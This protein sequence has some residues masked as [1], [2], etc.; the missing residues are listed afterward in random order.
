VRFVEARQ[1]EGGVLERERSVV[2]VVASAN[3]IESKSRGKA[4]MT[5]IHPYLPTKRI[6]WLASALMVAGV[7]SGCAADAKVLDAQQI[8]QQYGVSGAYTGSIATPDGPMHGT[9]IPITLDDGPHGTVD[10]S[11][12]T[13]Q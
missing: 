11:T 3:V 7:V 9:I 13:S 5:K 8:E 6:L 12:T 10:R 2:T 1:A 4:T